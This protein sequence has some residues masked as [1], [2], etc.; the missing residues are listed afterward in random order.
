[1]KGSSIQ[2]YRSIGADHA[3]AEMRLANVVSVDTIAKRWW[4][5]PTQIDEDMMAKLVLEMPRIR[6]TF[7]RKYSSE[8]GT[9]P[10]KE[11]FF[12]IYGGVDPVDEDETKQTT[13]RRSCI[14]GCGGTDRAYGFRLPGNDE[15]TDLYRTQ[16]G[17][18]VAGIQGKYLKTLLAI[19]IRQPDPVKYIQDA[20]AEQ[21]TDSEL[22]K[23]VDDLGKVTGLNGRDLLRI[24]ET[25]V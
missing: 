5:D 17:R 23:L 10:L 16:F 8:V 4:S 21:T 18:S 11:C 12:T 25:T 24:S 19:A 6:D 14:P 3:I 7:D 22:M 15:M 9:V 2:Q 20:L 13:Y 1:M